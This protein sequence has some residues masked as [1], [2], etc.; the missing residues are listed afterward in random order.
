MKPVVYP[1]IADIASMIVFE[2]EHLIILNKPF[3]LPS[4]PTADRGRTNLVDKIRDFFWLRDK[5][6]L[7]PG[8]IHRL[9]KDTSGL[10]V[11]LKDMKLHRAF[12]K[13]FQT[14]SIQKTYLAKVAGALKSENG[15]WEHE[16]SEF[17]DPTTKKV[18]LRSGPKPHDLVM[19]S[20]PVKYRLASTEYRVLKKQ[21]ETAL[22]EL[23]P[24]TGRM[25]QLRVQCAEAGCPI[26]GDVLYAPSVWQRHPIMYLHAAGLSFKHPATQKQLNLQSLPDWG[27]V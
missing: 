12:N 16:L 13:M 3:N 1:S 22:L 2:D 11:Y 19:G 7:E 15:T 4:Q 6:V 17:P 14:H 21:P 27:V 23:T 8:V 18:I 26:V 9:D 24:H 25:H 10:I 20:P 5:V